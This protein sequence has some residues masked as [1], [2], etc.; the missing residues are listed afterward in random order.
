MVT[1][2]ADLIVIRVGKSG[3]KPAPREGEQS[4]TLIDGIT[5]VARSPGISRDLV[6]RSRQGKRIYA[7]SVSPE[8]I[9]KIIR[10]DSKGKKTVGRLVNGQF[11]PLRPQAM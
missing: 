10:E 8:D 3:A 11:K 2:R 6:F 1:P 5:R 9:T 7:Y 4:A